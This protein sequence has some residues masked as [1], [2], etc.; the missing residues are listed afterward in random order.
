MR[1]P[2]SRAGWLAGA[3]LAGSSTLAWASPE[4]L[5]PPI[6]DQPAPAPTPAPVPRPTAAPAPAQ[7]SGPVVQPLPGIAPPQPGDGPGASVAAVFPSRGLKPN[8]GG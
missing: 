2:L 7:T 8:C 3:V 1:R 5:L 4:S 6:F